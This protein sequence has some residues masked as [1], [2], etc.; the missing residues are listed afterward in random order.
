MPQLIRKGIAR[1]SFLI[2][3][4]LGMAGVGTSVECSFFWFVRS[5]ENHDQTTAGGVVLGLTWVSVMA[6]HNQANDMKTIERAV[7]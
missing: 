7:Y 5:I 3:R 6:S 4:G 1:V 2:K